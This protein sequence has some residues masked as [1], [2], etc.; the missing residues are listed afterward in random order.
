MGKDKCNMIYKN[1]KNISF[2]LAELMQNFCSKI[3]FS[4]RSEQNLHL[5]IK[6]I[7]PL[8]DKLLGFGPMGAMITALEHSYVSWI[9]IACDLP[10]IENDAIKTLFENYNPFNYATAFQSEYDDLPEPLC[11]IY[12]PKIFISFLSAFSYGEK[13]P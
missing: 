8:Y 12:S 7:N 3:Y 11:T 4:C 9:V 2:Y 10:Y 5:D 13:M 1:N 6:T